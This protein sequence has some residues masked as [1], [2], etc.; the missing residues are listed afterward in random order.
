MVSLRPLQFQEFY[1]NNRTSTNPTRVRG[2]ARAWLKHLS[3][4]G[5][6]DAMVVVVVVVVIEQQNTT[7]QLIFS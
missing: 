1:T 7:A 3:R 4:I 5:P 2:C 6:A